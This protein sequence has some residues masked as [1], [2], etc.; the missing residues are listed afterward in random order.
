MAEWRVEVPAPVSIVQDEC[1]PR[2][3][4]ASDVTYSQYSG[5]TYASGPAAVRAATTLWPGTL[6]IPLD[7][8]IIGASVDGHFVAQ[9]QIQRY[10]NGG[11]RLNETQT[12]CVPPLAGARRAVPPLLA[13]RTRAAKQARPDG[14][15]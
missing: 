11:W 2:W 4:R 6:L 15:V 8:T 3:I 7:P 1:P 9:Y 10:R 12:L 5:T 13:I 14:P